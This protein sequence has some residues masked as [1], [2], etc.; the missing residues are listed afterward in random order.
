MQEFKWYLS[1]LHV[2][3]RPSKRLNH[4][5][6]YPPIENGC[7]PKVESSTQYKCFISGNT[8]SYNVQTRSLW[9][10]LFRNEELMKNCLWGGGR[11]LLLG[12]TTNSYSTFM[13]KNSSLLFWNWT[14]NDRWEMREAEDNFMSTIQYRTNKMSNSS[15]RIKTP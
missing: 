9:N 3:N 7:K 8:N 14:T 2:L 15:V 12:Q 5:L 13:V 11:D 10:R 6:Y 1:H 4:S